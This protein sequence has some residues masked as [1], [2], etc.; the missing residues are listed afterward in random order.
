M[1]PHPSQSEL[2]LKAVSR[3][4]RQDRAA[5]SVFP[6]PVSAH[7]AL[8]RSPPRAAPPAPQTVL[9]PSEP[10]RLAPP[11]A[12]GG[13]DLARKPLSPRTSALASRPAQPMA[14]KSRVQIRDWSCIIKT[15]P[16]PSPVLPLLYF[17]PSLRS[18]SLLCS[19]P[20]PALCGL[21]S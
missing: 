19:L 14:H 12:G 1:R 20:P 16:T 8:P 11:S 3:G 7:A 4:F 13:I 15:N 10:V 21:A 17:E 9:S 18:R 2:D 6:S 5:G